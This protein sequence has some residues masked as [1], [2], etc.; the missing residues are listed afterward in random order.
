MVTAL[1]IGVYVAAALWRIPPVRITI[2]ERV[3]IIALLVIQMWAASCGSYLFYNASLRR[4][5]ESCHASVFLQELLI[6]GLWSSLFAVPVLFSTSILYAWKI[7]EAW[8]QAIQVVLCV[9]VFVGFFQLVVP[10][11]RGLAGCRPPS[12]IFDNTRGLLIQGTSSCL[13]FSATLVF[14]QARGLLA[15]MALPFFML[16]SLM[17]FVEGVH[18]KNVASIRKTTTISARSATAGK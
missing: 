4:M 7:S 12:L 6:A 8:K 1:P 5:I 10:G 13:P 3:K 14:D 17:R 16:Y 2:R 15:G 18:G 9:I 11:S